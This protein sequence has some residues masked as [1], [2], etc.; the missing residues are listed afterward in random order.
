MSCAVYV[1]SSLQRNPS[2]SSRQMVPAQ[3]WQPLFS[4]SQGA[5]S[6]PQQRRPDKPSHSG[7]PA[8]SW[9]LI[10]PEPLQHF[11][12]PPHFLSLSL[13]RFFL[14]FL[15]AR[16]FRSSLETRPAR[17]AAAAALSVWRR[18][19]LPARVVE[20]RSKSLPF[21]VVASTFRHGLA[22][23]RVGAG[24]RKA[25]AVRHVKLSLP[26]YTRHDSCQL[27]DE[28]LQPM[29]MPPVLG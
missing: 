12:L 13:Q 8:T 5:P 19:A 23:A 7:L 14:F 3:H 27:L 28:A 29:G 15:A 6:R 22:M 17:P 26:A 20:M 11:F 21:I 2:G 18:G 1:K 4:G 16:S 24:G 10:R 9:H 25:V